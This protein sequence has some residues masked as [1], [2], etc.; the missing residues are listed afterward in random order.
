LVASVAQTAW[1]GYGAR[2][3]PQ[4]E[5]TKLAAAEVDILDNAREFYE[6]LSEAFD[7]VGDVLSGDIEP[8]ELRGGGWRTSLLS[9]STTIKALASAF[10]DLKFGRPGSRRR[11]AV[12]RFD[13]TGFP[14]HCPATRS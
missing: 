8:K 12:R 3:T 14:R 13:W 5:N 2:W 6:V 11:A 10:H 4:Q 7:D 9:S 1:L